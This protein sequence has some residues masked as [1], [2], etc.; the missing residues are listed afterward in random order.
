MNAK[1]ALVSGLHT[2]GHSGLFRP[3]LRRF[4]AGRVNVAFYHYTGDITPYYAAFY[5]NCTLQR[6]RRDL[7]ALRSDFEIVP[8]AKVIEFNLRKDAPEAPYLAIT[9]DDGF[10]LCRKEVLEIL[11]EFKIKVTSFLT[12]SCL[13]NRDLMWRNKLSVIQSS[14]EESILVAKYNQLMARVARPAIAKASQLMAATVDW[15]MSRKGEWADEL[16]KGCGLP[17]LREFLDEHRPYFTSQDLSGWIAAGHSIGF[18]TH[19][20]PFCSRLRPEDIETEILQ[21]ALRLK[22]RFGVAS[23]PF[24][25][26]FG[27]RLQPEDEKELFRKGVFNAAFGVR[28]SVKK[29]TPAHRLERTNVEGLGAGNVYA[30]L[31]LSFCNYGN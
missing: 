25:Y 15:D 1:K 8:L 21:P 10:N 17:P 19:T 20:H 27:D 22:E 28:G 26:P 31:L 24:S 29:N 13:D 5:E 18:H 30:R 14:V 3:R 16:W 2:V 11:D 9:F 7:A 12:T 4:A 6:F 23:L